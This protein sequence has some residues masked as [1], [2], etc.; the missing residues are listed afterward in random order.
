VAVALKAQK[1]LHAESDCQATAKASEHARVKRE[2]D[3]Q[4]VPK[5]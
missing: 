5:L 4:R 3:R 1:R 2:V